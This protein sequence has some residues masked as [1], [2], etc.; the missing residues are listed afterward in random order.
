MASWFSVRSILHNFYSYILSSYYGYIPLAQKKK[1]QWQWLQC[2]HQDLRTEAFTKLWLKKRVS[3]GFALGNKVVFKALVWQLGAI[4]MWK[5]GHGHQEWGCLLYVS[6][7]YLLWRA[8]YSPTI[9]QLCRKH[10]CNHGKEFANNIW[11]FFA[12]CAIQQVTVRRLWKKVY[13]ELGGSPGSTSA[14]TCTR[15]HY[16]K[17]E[18]IGFPTNLSIWSLYQSCH[19]HTSVR[20]GWCC[21]LKDT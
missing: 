12:H 19:N 10:C 9:G 8:I 13:D 5:I 20:P 16:E 4:F 1:T 21:P 14:A 11:T 15:R 2:W 3:G 17:W 6:L 7:E 18:L